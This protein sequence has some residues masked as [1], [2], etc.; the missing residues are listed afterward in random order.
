MRI[1]NQVQFNYRFYSYPEIFQYKELS[2]KGNDQPKNLKEL[3]TANEKLQ[4]RSL[5]ERQH[6]FSGI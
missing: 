3:N 5:F 1:Q 6:R 4:G 2:Q